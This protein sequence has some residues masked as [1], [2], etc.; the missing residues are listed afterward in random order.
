[1]LI[2]L[3]V[4]LAAGTLAFALMAF[5]R[6]RGSVKRRTARIMDE[7]DARNPKRS[8]RYSSLKAVAQLLEYTTKHYSGGNEADMRLLRKRLIQAGIYDPRGVAFFFIARTALAVLLA[9]LL[10]VVGPLIKPMGGSAHWLMA[11]LGGIAGYI[12]PSMYIDRRIASRKVEHRSGFPDFMDLL[13]VCADSGLSM[14]AALERVGRELGESYPSLTANIHVTNLEIR[15]GR[16]LKEALD[17]FGDRLALEEARAFAT[18]INQSIDLGSSITDALRVYSDDMRHKRLSRAEEKAYA[19]PAKLS[20]PMM[21]CIFPV[22]F[23]VILLPVFVRL[24]TG[25]YF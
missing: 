17:R 22:L 11:I 18:L 6:V 23:V 20:V 12:G 25:G 24:H 15:A 21:V 5:V 7:D 2:M 14:E 13:V 10:F 9:I 1:M 3:L 16:N 8:L 19:L 4:F